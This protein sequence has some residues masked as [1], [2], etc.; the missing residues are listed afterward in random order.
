M[1]SHLSR[2]KKQVLDHIDEIKKCSSEREKQAKRT[3]YGLR[4][5]YN[6]LFILPIDLYR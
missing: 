4:E 5:N 1:I 6:P 3:L 2:S